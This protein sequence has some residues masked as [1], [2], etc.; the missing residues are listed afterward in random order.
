MGSGRAHVAGVDL[1]F[2]APKSV[3]VLFA[4]GGAEVATSVAEAHR[5][6]VSGA[7]SY[8]ERHALAAVRREG[9]ER[10]VIP[11]SG[12]VAGVFT[13]AVNR[14][15]DPHVHSHVVMVNLVH[16][17]D[18]RWGACD[19]RGL[20]AHRAAAG[21]I[22]EA[23]LR[24]GL[25]SALGVS[26]TRPMQGSAEI[27][28]VDPVLRGEFSSRSADIRRHVAAVGSRTARGQR[29]AWAV[30]RPGKS[31]APGFAQLS[32]DWDRRAQALG[33]APLAVTRSQPMVRRAVLDE[34]GFAAVLSAT[35]HGGA[36]RR[37]VVRAF[38]T[39]ARDGASAPAVERVTDLWLPSGGV[40]V[41]E[42]IHRRGDASPGRHLVNEL[43]PRPVDPDAHGVW[44]DA[45][46]VIE[47]YRQ[48]WG[49]GRSPEA[50]GGAPQ[51]SLPVEQLV[52]HLRTARHVEVARARLG[53]REVRQME[54]GR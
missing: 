28:G 51:A 3:S 32:A 11:T 6:A 30:T 9:T 42:P 4:L 19:R 14:S 24:D 29:V 47:H 25:R 41:N 44:H 8:V 17:E 15:H 38:A 53:V 31:A 50:L 48:R 36:Y 35:P 46:M 7:V 1:T 33:A 16:G 26:W 22:Y 43:G 34:H 49:L 39:A 27:V 52:D 54:L 37:D 12:M 5:T 18:G 40:G 20:D 10:H 23:Q 21:A 2:S 13:H 45:A